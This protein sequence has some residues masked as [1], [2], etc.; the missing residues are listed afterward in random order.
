MTT[1]KLFQVYPKAPT[2]NSVNGLTTVLFLVKSKTQSVSINH[3]H[4]GNTHQDDVDMIMSDYIIE[5][6]EVSREIIEFKY[7]EMD[8]EYSSSEYNQDIT[9]FLGG[10]Y[11]ILEF[12][13]EE[14]PGENKTEYITIQYS[15]DGQMII[16]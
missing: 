12:H 10:R 15:L 9:T 13:L 5:E 4:F 3:I 7:D 8:R 14:F 11:V 1:I 6:G 2:L 16:T